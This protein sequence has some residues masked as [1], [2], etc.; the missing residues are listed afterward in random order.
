MA[1]PRLA[2]ASPRLRNESFEMR[3]RELP[4][5]GSPFAELPQTES[6]AIDYSLCR[7]LS[8]RSSA[9]SIGKTLDFVTLADAQHNGFGWRVFADFSSP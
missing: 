1:A 7:C 5:I 3:S 2:H 9:A 6:A 4:L 8:G